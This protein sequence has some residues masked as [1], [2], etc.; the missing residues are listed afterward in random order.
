M[1]LSCRVPNLEEL[2]PKSYATYKSIRRVVEGR[3]D[4]AKR[5]EDLDVQGGE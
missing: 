5:E 4:E 3:E 2:V 1:F